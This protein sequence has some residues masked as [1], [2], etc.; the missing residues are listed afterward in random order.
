VKLGHHPNSILRL[1]VLRMNDGTQFPSQA[2]VSPIK[3]GNIRLGG[4]N[5]LK[6]NRPGP[7]TEVPTGLRD[8]VVSFAKLHRLRLT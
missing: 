7:L 6:P 4:A 2:R 1:A 8:L 3:K 5:T